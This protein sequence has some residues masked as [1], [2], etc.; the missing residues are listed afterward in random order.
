MGPGTTS[1]RVEVGNWGSKDDEFQICTC[2]EAEVCGGADETFRVF[3]P[4]LIYLLLSPY[5]IHFSNMWMQ[6]NLAVNYSY[7]G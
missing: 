6:L 5:F 2:K 3:R 7:D 4:H 1:I